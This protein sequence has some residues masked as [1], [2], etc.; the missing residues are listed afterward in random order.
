MNFWH[1]ILRWPVILIAVVACT[2]AISQTPVPATAS[3]ASAAATTDAPTPVGK[4]DLVTGEV[5]VVRSGSTPLRVVAGDAVN[6]GDLLVTGKDSEVHM[7][8]Q[9]SGFIALR[10]S[11]R[12]RIVKYKADGG[13]DDKGVFNLLVGGMRSVTGWIG[14]FNRAAYQVR[15]PSATI[16]IRGTDHETRYLPDGSSDGEPGTY[17]KVFAG[18]TTI[19][20]KVG[21]ANV[22]P[23]QAGF[24]SAQGREQPR[25]LDQVPVFFRPGPNEAVINQKHAEIQAQIG[26]RREERRKIVL[27]KR[28]AVDAT[29]VNGRSQV[30]ENKVVSEQRR[31]TVEQQRLDTRQQRETLREQSAKHK[32]QRAAKIHPGAG[33]G[34][35][36]KP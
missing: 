10:P 8:M 34:A 5:R 4:I 2:F 14:Q 16:G 27:D 33:Q 32:G 6:E 24:V 26:Q 11:T 19:R 25:I 7:T 3:S 28:A 22:E 35:S 20:T 29:R 30:E 18:G 23:D 31:A 9:D 17:D 12:M 1:R 21:Q 13:T 36:E 15:T